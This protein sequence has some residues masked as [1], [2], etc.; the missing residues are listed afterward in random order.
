MRKPLGAGMA[1]TLMG[2]LLAISLLTISLA[3]NAAPTAPP[4]VPGS[5]NVRWNPGALDCRR[6][7]EPA[8]QVHAYNASTYILRESLCATSEAPFMYLLIGAQRA[9]LIDTGDIADPVR[10]PLARTVLD[11][12]PM[13]PSGRLPLL[14]VHSHCH[15]DHRAGDPQFAHL[16]GVEVVGYDLASLKRFYGF[17]D[18]PSGQAT[19]DLGRR[20]VD[21]LPAPG[22]Q[23]TEAVFY[24]R[25]TALM[26]TGDFLLPGRLLVDD[27][28]ADAASA[29]RIAAFAADKPVAHVLGGQIEMNLD[30]GL[31]GFGSRFHPG[32]RPLQL[33]KTE[34]MALP[35]IVEGF[36]GVYARRSGFTLINQAYLIELGEAALTIIGLV[37]IAGLAALIIRA[38]R[39]AVTFKGRPVKL[40]SV[41]PAEGAPAV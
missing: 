13:S 41:M 9:L 6:G 26:F 10:A 2:P 19:L 38:R 31:Y 1:Q 4:L 11:L 12:L 35:G 14:V 28:A 16:P 20:Q 37:F 27:A 36:R 5:M 18:W 30:G 32:E 15:P 21:V 24:D 22:H 39:W 3:A 40:T 7:A 33:S 17:A 8:I 29:R 34:L 23:E 25:Q